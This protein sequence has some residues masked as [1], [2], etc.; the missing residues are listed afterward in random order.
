MNP[1][2][3]PWPWLAATLIAAGCATA[4]PPPRAEPLFDD[5]AFPPASERIDAAEVF[6]TS[7]AMR[8]FLRGSIAETL[9][10][11]GPQV[12]LFEA[13]YNARQLK[14]EYDSAPTR[15]AAQAFDARAG[16]CLSLVIMTAALAK[17]LGLQ[18]RFQQVSADNAWSRHGG[19]YFVS[20][21]VNVTR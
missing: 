16:N 19:T 2:P 6:A 7:D 3:W 1:W 4:P 11:R 17:E 18:V 14:L 13:L 5:A 15:N 21:H 20:A 10:A 9:R 8:R 12:G